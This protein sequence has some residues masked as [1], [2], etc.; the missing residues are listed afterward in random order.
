M[1]RF[2]KHIVIVLAVLTLP[3]CSWV[4]V[5]KPPKE[6]MWDEVTYSGCT[7]NKAAPVI[8]T[9]F[10]VSTGLNALCCNVLSLPF[11]ALWTTSA[12]YGFDETEKCERFKRQAEKE[13]ESTN[14]A[15]KK[16]P[17][18]PKESKKHDPQ[19]LEK[20]K[21]CQQQG[22]V[23]VNDTC[24]IILDDNEENRGTNQAEPDNSS[25]EPAQK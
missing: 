1:V 24:Q 8:D 22:G 10:A 18:S 19:V 23:W 17:E 25:A 12:Y 3:G 14:E 6:P 4:T 2:M 13:D 9:I 5:N 16:A 7:D 15:P 21:R 20:A 11:A